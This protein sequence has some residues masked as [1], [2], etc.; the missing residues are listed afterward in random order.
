LPGVSLVRGCRRVVR[1]EGFSASRSHDGCRLAHDRR[2][3]L[4]TPADADCYTG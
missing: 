4:R 2:D 1:E 3:S